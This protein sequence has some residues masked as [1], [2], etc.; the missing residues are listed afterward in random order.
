M[1]ARGPERPVVQ[2][3]FNFLAS[4][5]MG[6][7]KMPV[8]VKHMSMITNDT[9]PFLPLSIFFIMAFSS[10]Q[11]VNDFCQCNVKVASLWTGT[12]AILI[13]MTFEDPFI[14]RFSF[15]ADFQNIG[16]SQIY[17]FISH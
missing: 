14:S 10:F 4:A 13:S 8:S 2:R 5:S 6:L 11:N 3:S 9:D 1:E 15:K 16:S 7:I 12:I 17:G